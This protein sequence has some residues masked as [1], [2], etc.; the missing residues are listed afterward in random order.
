MCNP[1]LIL[2][3]F[4]AEAI[5]LLA[6]SMARNT[7]TTYATALELFDQLRKL[8]NLGQIW[9]P[10]VDHISN[11]VAYLSYSR[12]S[13]ST[14]K[15]YMSG[16]SFV[17]KS[18]CLADTT[19]EFLVQKMIKGATKLYQMPD[20]RFPIAINM[21]Y[22]FPEV[23]KNVCF[24]EK[25]VWFHVSSLRRVLIIVEC[26]LFPCP[27]NG[28]SMRFLYVLLTLHINTTHQFFST[29]RITIS[30]LFLYELSL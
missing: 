23:L 28:G 21:M 5:E 17:L 9:P 16:I 13:P 7:G 26:M 29:V 2:E 12:Y 11:F 27:C 3:P 19:Q 20:S 10:P 24:S 6:A 4:W 22:R 8:F 15:S 18:R 25:R 30:P 14:I 1:R